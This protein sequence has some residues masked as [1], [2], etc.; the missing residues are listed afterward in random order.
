VVSTTFF[1][2]TTGND[3]ANTKTRTVSCQNGTHMTGGGYN[4]NV[5]DPDLVLQRSSP[6]GANSWVAQ[7][8]EEQGFGNGSWSLTVYVV[9]AH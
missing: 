1:S 9:C 3:G 7:V 5:H 6:N 8:T 4:T 2:S